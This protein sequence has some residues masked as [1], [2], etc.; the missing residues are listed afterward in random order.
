MPTNR[1]PHSSQEC[2]SSIEVLGINHNCHQETAVPSVQAFVHHCKRTWQWARTQLQQLVSTFE[3][4]DNRHWSATTRYHVGQIGIICRRIYLSRP[5]PGNSPQG[6]LINPCFMRLALPLSIGQ[7]SPTFH[8]SQV[9]LL[10]P[11]PLSISPC[12]LHK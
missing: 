8:V 4:K 6:S 10:V 11:C 7:V 12:H 5:C 1:S 2:H 9:Y 3:C